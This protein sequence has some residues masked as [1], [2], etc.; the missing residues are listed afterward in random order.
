MSSFLGSN[1]CY[2]VLELIEKENWHR[3]APHGVGK[4]RLPFSHQLSPPKIKIF[5]FSFIIVLELIFRDHWINW[6]WMMKLYPSP[7]L[8]PK[9]KLLFTTILFLL[10]TSGRYLLFYVIQMG[11][12]IF[13]EIEAFDSK[14]FFFGKYIYDILKTHHWIKSCNK[15]SLVRFAMPQ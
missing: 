4:H 3:R 9:L 2:A 1:L 6:L 14:A 12:V 10:I 5:L 7:L 15:F 11:F 8:Y 13:V